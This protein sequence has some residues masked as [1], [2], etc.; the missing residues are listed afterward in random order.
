MYVRR[1]AR[2]C[3]GF[4]F[5]ALGLGFVPARAYIEARSRFVGVCG[6]SFRPQDLANRMARRAGAPDGFVR[7]TV[8]FALP[9]EEARARARA[10]WRN[11]PSLPT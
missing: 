1:A 8:T 9:R 5:K 7:V 11:I 10:F 2:R 6:M 3:T 4:A